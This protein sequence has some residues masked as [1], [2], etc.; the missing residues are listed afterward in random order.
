MT[1]EVRPLTSIRGVAASLVAVYHFHQFDAIPWAPLANLVRRGYFWVDLFFVLSGFVMAMTYGAMFTARYDG[2]AHRAFLLKRIARIYP[3]YLAVTLAVSLY[4]L[5][6]YHGYQGVHRPGVNLPHPVLAHVTN[7]LMIQA[8]GF[9]SSI[10]GPTW[11]ISTEWAAYLVFPPLLA[12]TLYRG[13]AAAWLTGLGAALLLWYVGTHVEA[14]QTVRNGQLD[15]FHCHDAAA[16]L[17][18]VAGFNIGLLAFRV[19]G[20]AAARALLG[21]DAVCLALF[22]ALLA[23]MAL[24]ID[25]LALY[26][27]LPLLVIA[28]ASVKGWARTLFSAPPLYALGVLSYAIYL[29]HDHF[30]VLLEQLDLRLPHYLPAALAPWVAAAIT[31]AGVLAT[32]AVS[33]RVIEKPWR[34]RLRRAFATG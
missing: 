7:L 8:W 29:V 34:G 28:L 1:D 4:T 5:A 32:A 26:P 9:G 27:L 21:R 16:V 24:Q 10:G 15:L 17:R 2:A 14:G 31:Y 22:L 11:T 13:A 20:I 23:G 12:L 30:G 25:D 19:Q 3:L 33:Y 6:V 18:C